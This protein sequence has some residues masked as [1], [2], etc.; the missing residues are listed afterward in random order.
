MHTSALF[1]ALAVPAVLA[2][3]APRQHSM[4][5]PAAPTAAAP[6]AAAPTAAAPTAPMETMDHETMDHAKPTATPKVPSAYADLAKCE[7]A[8]DTLLQAFSQIPIPYASLSSFLATE[9]V[10]VADPCSWAADVPDGLS[11]AYSAYSSNYVDILSEHADLV[12]QLSSCVDAGGASVT[13]AEIVTPLFGLAE[14]KQPST[15][16]GANST[17]AAQTGTTTTRGFPAGQTST[18]TA[19]ARET[20]VA[21]AGVAAAAL[22]GIAGVF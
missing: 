3:V 15:S 9:T 14:C 17:P 2:H 7:L 6:V 8:I 1:F 10:A 18:S 22:F 5:M 21:M 4:D 19:G 13:R 20:G 11:S 12:T 16:S